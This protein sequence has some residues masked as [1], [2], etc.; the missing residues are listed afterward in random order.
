MLICIQIDILE[1]ELIMTENKI[2]L[3]LTGKTL[4]YEK[5]IDEYTA[6]QIVALCAGPLAEKEV[7][8]KHIEKPN[9]LT[10]ESAAEYMN[11][12]TPKRNP[13]K[14]LTL[15][16]YIIDTYQKDSFQPNEIKNLFRDAGEVVPAN[17]N[18]DFNWAVRNAW[19]AQDHA[20]KGNYYITNTGMKVLR[21]NF[22]DDLIKRTKARAKVKKKTKTKQE[23]KK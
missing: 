23:K 18:R 21:E 22:P 9:G 6:S 7:R 15:A 3:T 12:H 16:G 4:S 14:I 17:F 5:E 19:I 2:K 20:K 10:R 1:M 13:D 8:A 11:R